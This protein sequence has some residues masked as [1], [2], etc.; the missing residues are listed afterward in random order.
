[1]T[2]FFA[3]LLIGVLLVCLALTMLGLPGNWL[4]VAATAIYAYLTS[5]QSSAAIGWKPIVV[6]LVLASLGE[7]IELLAA[8]TGTAKAGGSKRSAAL[9]LAGSI[10]GAVIGIIV[11]IP[12]PLLGPILAA[13][14]FAGLGACVGA[15]LGELWVGQNLDASWR[16]GQAAFWGRLAGTL[17]K[18]LVGVVMV[19]VVVVALVW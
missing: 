10:A 2:I 8:A 5:A 7:V 11:G 17:G 4:I 3:L 9:A 1:M 6:L 18:M 13:L 16:I 19:A 14:L 12:V 15:M